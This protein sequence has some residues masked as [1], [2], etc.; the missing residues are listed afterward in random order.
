MGEGALSEE[1]L[2]RLRREGELAPLA[3]QKGT[4]PIT[5]R[6]TP[7]AVMLLTVE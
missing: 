1:D 3:V 6:F 5:L 7:N 4:A 2:R